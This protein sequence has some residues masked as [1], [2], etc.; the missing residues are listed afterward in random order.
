MRLI[1]FES[2][3]EYRVGALDD[4]VCGDL[5]ATDLIVP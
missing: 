1:T 5:N 3:G 2:G 4:G